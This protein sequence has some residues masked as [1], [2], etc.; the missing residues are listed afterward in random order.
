M[1]IL[2]LA[3]TQAKNPQDACDQVEGFIE[4]FGDEN[5]YNRIEGCISQH[6]EVHV[7][8]DTS[9]LD[10]ELNSIEKIK[11]NVKAWMTDGGFFELSESIELLDKARNGEPLS[12]T[13]W[14]KIRVY[15]EHMG[16]VAQLEYLKTN[17]NDFDIFKHTFM[18]YKYTENGVTRMYCQDELPE[19]EQYYVVFINMHT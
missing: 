10:S 2:H 7:N 9:F 1:H 3:V 11:K 12:S 13:D 16:A 18:D 14:Y 6:D 4:D 15:A 19:D 5:N 17:P 8:E